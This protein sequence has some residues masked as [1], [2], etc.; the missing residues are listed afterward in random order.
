MLGAHDKTDREVEISIVAASTRWWLSAQVM[1]ACILLAML[2]LEIS[3]ARSSVNEFPVT[4][5]SSCTDA[6][7]TV[8]GSIAQALE[9]IIDDT[10]NITNQQYTKAL[11]LARFMVSKTTNLTVEVFLLMLKQIDPVVYCSVTA[12]N[13]MTATI[14]SDLHKGLID[15]VTCNAGNLCNNQIAVDIINS[16]NDLLG[17]V[18]QGLDM[19]PILDGGVDDI[20]LQEL[21]ANGFSQYI[22]ALENFS[23]P[24]TIL[25]LNSTQ[26]ITQ[27]MENVSVFIEV[28]QTCHEAS[29][30][31]V[32][33]SHKTAQVMYYIE[34]AVWLSIAL[35]LIGIF[36]GAIIKQFPTYISKWVEDKWDSMILSVEHAYKNMEVKSANSRSTYYFVWLMKY[37]NFRLALIS[38]CYGALGLLMIYN[39]ANFTNETQTKVDFWVE[40]G[41]GPAMTKIQNQL[42]QGINEVIENVQNEMNDHLRLASGQQL[43]DINSVLAKIITVKG[44]YQNYTDEALQHLD[45][46]PVLGPSLVYMVNCMLPTTFFAIVDEAVDILVQFTHDVFNFQVVLPTYTFPYMAGTATSASHTAVNFVVKTVQSELKKYQYIFIFLCI[47]VGILVF[48]GIIFLGFK[49][50][51]EKIETRKRVVS[52]HG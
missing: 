51:I 37:V 27:A 24:A 13:S 43:E 34:I 5:N 45:D 30:S 31:L 15:P 14:R 3:N 16:L 8:K 44:T 26:I 46:I 32:E 12:A 9:I 17:Y 40:V 39:L 41:L 29:S 19:W 18:N 2:A 20:L 1:I 35:L 36:I 42:Q 38:T 11:N 28:I 21:A 52:A 23:A 33:I 47:A 7:V 48:Q 50:I 4:L 10:Q 49:R 25:N 6:V 22:N